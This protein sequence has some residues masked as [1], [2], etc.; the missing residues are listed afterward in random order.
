MK[1]TAQLEDSFSQGKLDHLREKVWHFLCAHQESLKIFIKEFEETHGT[2]ALD[3]LTKYWILTIDTPFD[4][5]D[6]LKEQTEAIQRDL[7]DKLKDST[8]RSKY[9][10]EWVKQNA[11]GFRHHSMLEQ[12]YCFEKMKTEL[13]PDLAKLLNYKGN[14]YHAESQGKG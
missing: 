3:S 5:R 2:W 7:G 1:L 14:L 12:I 11:A 10:A 13:L 6:Y 4:L 9:V 8:Q